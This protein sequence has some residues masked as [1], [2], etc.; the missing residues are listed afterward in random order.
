MAWTMSLMP[1]QPPCLEIFNFLRPEQACLQESCP[2]LQEA[3]RA[4]RIQTQRTLSSEVVHTPILGAETAASPSA[5]SQSPEALTKACVA[6]TWKW[7]P[8]VLRLERKNSDW[9]A[10]PCAL[11]EEFARASQ[12]LHNKVRAGSWLPLTLSFPECCALSH[13]LADGTEWP[14]KH[15]PKN[16]HVWP[17]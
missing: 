4:H 9:G 8:P 16:S 15:H 12:T 11:V 17:H 7:L 13:E 10:L 14:P 2:T 3:E 1:P 5:L 6:H